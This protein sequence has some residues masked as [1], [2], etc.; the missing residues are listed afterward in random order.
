MAGGHVFMALYIKGLCPQLL[1]DVSVNFF[2][3]LVG[4]TIV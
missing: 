4:L 1:L 2:Q 3:N